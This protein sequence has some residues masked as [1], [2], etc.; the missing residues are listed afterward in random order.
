MREELNKN[1]LEGTEN[2]NETEELVMVN[3]GLN[4]QIK[5]L[6]A[7]LQAERK[8][9]Q[10]A[11]ARIKR[12]LAETQKKYDEK[13]RDAMQRGKAIDEVKAEAHRQVEEASK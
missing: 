10:Q 4:D 6:Q 5:T 3:N 2:N 11:E 8:A 1:F 13:N 12:D 7:Q 9:R